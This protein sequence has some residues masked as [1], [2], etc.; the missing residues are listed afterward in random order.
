MVFFL[1]F[2]FIILSECLQHVFFFFKIFIIIILSECLQ[3]GLDAY[4]K[5]LIESSE[6]WPLEID[7]IY[8]KM[9]WNWTYWN[10]ITYFNFI[11]KWWN[12]DSINFNA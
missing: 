12:W 2:F 9:N 3:H 11:L 7:M 4:G 6:F 10:L 8:D 1:K 5:E